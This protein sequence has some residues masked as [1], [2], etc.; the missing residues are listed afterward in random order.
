VIV[1]QNI[2]G[3]AMGMVGYIYAAAWV[4]IPSSRLG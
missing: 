4:V 3:Y 1:L 2:V